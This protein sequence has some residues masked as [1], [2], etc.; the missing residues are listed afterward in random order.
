MW[1]YLFVYLP[2]SREYPVRFW[3]RNAGQT[4]ADAPPEAD[5]LDGWVDEQH[6]DD[7]LAGLRLRYPAPDP[8][9]ERMP[10]TSWQAVED[11]FP[12]LYFH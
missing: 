5:D 3:I 7:L 12:G 6:A 2:A 11:N 9:V 4:G 8:V 10:G 1:D